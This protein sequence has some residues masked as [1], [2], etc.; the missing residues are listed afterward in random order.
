MR[1]LKQR[2]WLAVAALVI[3]QTPAMFAV[4]SATSPKRARVDRQI[5]QIESSTGTSGTVSVVIRH[6]GSTDWNSLLKTL[7]SKGIK[8]G[9]Q[10]R[11]S[12]AISLKISKTD[13]AYLETLPGVGSISGDAPVASDPMSAQ[14]V[15]DQ[16]G[17]GGVRKASQLR[18]QLGFTDSDPTGNGIGVAVID[19]G[20]AAVPDLAGRISAFYDFT[21]GQGG[22]PAAPVDGYGHGTHVAGL[23]AGNGAVSNGQFEGVAP[24]AHLIGLRVLDNSGSGSTSDV[25]AAVEFAI[26]N[27]AALGIDIINLSLGHPPY[28]SAATDPLVQAVQAATQAGIVVVV[29]AGNVG[30]NPATNQIGYAGILS[31]GNAPNAITVGSAKPMGTIDPT[32]DLVANYSSRGPSWYD[33]FAKPDVAVPGQMLL[34]PAAPGSFLATTY[35]TLLTP[36]GNYIA[37]SGT[38]MAAGVESGLVAVVLEANREARL[39]PTAPDLTANAIKAFM[40]YTAIPMHD[41][42]GADYDRLSQ[43][44]GRVNGQGVMALAQSVDTSVPVGSPWL[45]TAVVPSS[46]YDGVQIPWAQN[47]VWGNNIV[48][49]ENINGGG[50]V[51]W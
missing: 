15:F 47:L 11:R 26:A 6:D 20:I 30:V 33:G 16:G 29:S 38:S 22:I 51:V 23:I 35:P 24:D 46:T 34:A 1:L 40:E 27:K 18:D 32:D 17:A 37:L 41:A 44:A 9:R 50:N 5:E 7:K 39:T 31:P 8:V 19:S 13:L 45:T 12:G 49:G 28:E 21:N 4:K 36:D 25:I 10:A 3:V 42:T 48:W 14:N 2:T 43:G